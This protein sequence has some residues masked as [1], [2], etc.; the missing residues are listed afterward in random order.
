[1]RKVGIPEADISK[2]FNI[3]IK[4]TRTGTT[5]ESGTGLGL[6]LCKDLIT[7]NKGELTVE[8]TQG[9]GSTFIVRLPA[10]N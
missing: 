8:S 2:L 3:D 7:R 10:L 6:I 1:M 9:V 5:G 4:Y